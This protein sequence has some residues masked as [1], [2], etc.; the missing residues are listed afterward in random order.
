MDLPFQISVEAQTFLKE[1]LKRT[2]KS[3]E[4]ALIWTPR[5]SVQD[6]E[7]G[8]EQIELG[9]GFMLGLYPQGKQPR[10]S[11]FEV[12]GYQVSILKSTLEKLNGKTLLLQSREVIVGDKRKAFRRL[13]A[14]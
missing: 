10:D 6:P 4:P 8:E 14:S 3:Y 7:L 13:N 1:S 2:Q 5:Q 9:E 12:C 11:F